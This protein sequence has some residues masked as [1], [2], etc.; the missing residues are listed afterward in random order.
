MSN[1][2]AHDAHQPTNHPSIQRGKVIGG[3][4]KARGKERN[5]RKLQLPDA[6]RI[7]MGCGFGWGCGNLF[8][9]RRFCKS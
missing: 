1:K 5:I 4:K 6:A 8:M 3:R 9:S 2:A 7:T